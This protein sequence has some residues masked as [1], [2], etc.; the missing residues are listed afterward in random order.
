MQQLDGQTLRENM[1]V[2]KGGQSLTLLQVDAE[3]E[4]HGDVSS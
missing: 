2:F 3:A 4:L 1:T